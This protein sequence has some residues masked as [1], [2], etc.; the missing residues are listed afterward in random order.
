MKDFDHWPLIGGASVPLRRHIS[1]PD[2]SDRLEFG[3]AGGTAKCDEHECDIVGT[4]GCNIEVRFG[5]KRYFVKI[6]DVVD[7]AYRQFKK[8][9]EPPPPC[10]CHCY[11]G[12]CDPYAPCA[13]P[14]EEH[15]PL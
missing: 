8:D 11:G 10:G 5:E 13:N 3:I 6:E 2:G 15:T 14:C 7:A 1:A 4:V 9:M 12:C